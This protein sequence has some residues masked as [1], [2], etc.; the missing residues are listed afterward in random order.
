MR[1]LEKEMKIMNCNGDQQLLLVLLLVVL[2]LLLF[3]QTSDIMCNIW[4]VQLQYL[5]V[6][7]YLHENKVLTMNEYEQK[8]RIHHANKVL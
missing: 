1:A 8:Y 5:A 6:A 7:V 3:I 2:L 4:L